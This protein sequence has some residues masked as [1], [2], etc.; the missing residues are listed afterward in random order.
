MWM[1]ERYPGN[2]RMGLPFIDSFL[3]TSEPQAAAVQHILEAD[4]LGRGRPCPLEGA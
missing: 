3:P 2:A 1:H 4:A